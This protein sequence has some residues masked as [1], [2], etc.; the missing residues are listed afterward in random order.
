VQLSDL[1]SSPRELV[2]ALF[3]ACASALD[4][5][6]VRSLSVWAGQWSPV[7][8]SVSCCLVNKGGGQGREIRT[9]NF[10][11]LDVE[12]KKFNLTDE[13]APKTL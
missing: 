13:F 5:G 9:T 12:K 7:S 3:L 4:G 6:G 1:K 11:G 2:V 8:S 10:V